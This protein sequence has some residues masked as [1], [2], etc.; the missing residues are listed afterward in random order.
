[1]LNIPEIEKKILDSWQ[2]NKVFKKSLEKKS[3]KG[4]FVFYDGPP[5]ATGTPHYGHIVASLMKDIV[6]RYWTMQGYRVERKWGW[7]CHGLPIENI[8][9]EEL[10]LKHKKEIEEIGVDKFNETARNK[11]LT[12]TEEWKKV[13]GR[14]GR[15]ADMDNAYKTMDL[16]YMESVW[17][18]FKQL[19]DKKLIY[20]GYKSMH[21]CPRCETTL[22]QHEVSDNYQDIEDISVIAKFELV[23]EPKNYVLAWTTTPW[24]LPGNVAL[25]MGKKLNYVKVKADDGNYI[26][27]EQNLESI[28]KDKKHEI[29]GK[30]NAENLEGKK[31]KPLFDYFLNKDWNPPAGGKENLYT[32]QLADFVT[33]E[34]GTGVVHIAPAFG[35]DDM[36]LGKEKNLPFIQH[37]KMNGQI[38]DEVIDFRGLEV[39]PKGKPQ[40]TDEKVIDFLKKKNLVFK[41]EKFT[42][43][44]P[45]CYRCDSPLL[46]YATSSLFVNITELKEKLLKNAQ[47]IN[48]VP[49]HIKDGRFGK[50]LEG[51]RDWSISRQRFWGSVIPIWVCD[52]CKEKKVIGSIKELEELSGEKITDLHKH[53]MD[54]ITFPC[55]KCARSTNSGEGG[56]MKR[57]S[58]VLDCWFESGSMPYGQAHYPFENKGKFE[59][60]FPA[61][62][63]AEGADQTRAWFYYLHVLAVAVKNSEAFKNVVVNGIVLAEDGKKMSKKLGNYPD[64]M[65][66]F[67]KYG[68]DA[69][70]YYLATSPV[71]K[72]ED[73]CFSEKTVDEMVKKVLLILLNIFSFYKMFELDIE[74]E[75]KS[76]NLL[77]KWILSKIES[78]R[79][80]ITEGYDSYDLNQATKPI[81]QFINDLSTWYL[82]RSRE[83]F[84]SE[85]KKE[86]EGAAK[87]LKYVL[88]ELS[89]IMAPVMPF[90]ADYIYKELSKEKES[91]HLEDWP[92]ENKKLIDKELEEKMEQVRQICSLAL[93]KRAEAGIKVRQPLLKLKIK[94]EKLKTEKELI[95]LIKDEINVREVICDSKLKEDIELD[96]KI[97]PELEKEGL[98]RDFIRQIQVKR[99]EAGLTPKDK[100]KVYF[101]NEELKEIVEKN[102]EQIKKQVIAEGIIFQV[103][104][105]KIEKS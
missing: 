81:E 21:I 33:I 104:E 57:V 74:A 4:D 50:W 87:T 100:I 103:G 86:K 65:E 42:H 29:V 16:N 28:F 19:W 34:D 82:R 99:K 80:K 26:L 37:V 94:N 7:D 35:E 61:E 30:I 96:T 54:K 39:K 89:K 79:K 84:K 67:E 55:E 5:F 49:E 105:L 68:A 47:K 69:V 66:V 95:N 6:P 102:K 76:N 52:K 8:V 56:T 71:M 24:T 98:I 53:F 90:T 85:D 40:S 9:E 10:G 59:K 77:D 88:L 64:P 31:Y 72:A 2:K 17:W 38:T 22:S 78:L 1:M 25:A 43:S 97:T 13:I 58:D 36:N 20:E 41:T 18:V 12:Y 44:Y 14:L 101:G 51:A 48:W 27:V 23:D 73:L 70:R 62:F 92:K 46:N 91:V 32:I 75:F 15:W 60:N 3:P 11:V 45:F 83:R 93:E 63:I